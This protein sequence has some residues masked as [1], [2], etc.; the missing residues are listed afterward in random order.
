MYN[1]YL[2]NLSMYNVYKGGHR[3]LGG[4][5]VEITQNLSNYISPPPI[6]WHFRGGWLVPT[7]EQG[8]GGMVWIK[9]NLVDTKNL[10]F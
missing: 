3:I 7:N 2:M 4:A 1:I 9:K 6:K 10:M 8:G 5:R